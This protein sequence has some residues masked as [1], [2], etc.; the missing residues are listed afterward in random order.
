MARVGEVAALAPPGLRRRALLALPLAAGGLTGCDWHRQAQREVFAAYVG[1]LLGAPRSGLDMPVWDEPA[2][3]PLTPG[4]M[5]AGPHP[6]VVC[7]AAATDFRR[8]FSEA[9][10]VSKV[11]RLA[12]ASAVHSLLA[13]TAVPRHVA[14]SPAGLPPSVT[15]EMVSETDLRQFFSPQVDLE[16]GWA[17]FHQRF[18]GNLGLSKFSTAGFRAD[19]RQ[20]VFVYEQVR[21]PLHGTGHAVLMHRAQGAWRLQEH[22]MLWIS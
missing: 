7:T 10:A 5:S 3:F 2:F 16:A 13:R 11:L 22:R 18:P 1:V 14:L 20:A 6:L 8:D 19:G 15:V 4:E 12:Q 21:G 17:S 9:A